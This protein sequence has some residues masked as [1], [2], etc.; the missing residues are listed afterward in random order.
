MNTTFV[1]HRPLTSYFVFTFAISWSA[2]FA[3]VAHRLLHGE[4]IP[5]FSGIPMFPAMLLGPAASGILMTRL[6]DGPAGIRKLFSS[7]IRARVG[8]RWYSILLLPPTAVLAVLLTLKMFVSPAFAP[9]HFFLGVVFGIPAGFFEEIGWTGFAFPRMQARFGTLQAGV[10]LGLLWS[11]WHLPVIDFLGAASPHGTYLPLFFLSFA[12]AMTAMR[13]LI[14]WI[15]ENTQSLL[16]AQF[17]HISSTGAL[18]V[19]GPFQVT[20]AQETA[21]YATYGVGLWIV[22]AALVAWFGPALWGAD[23]SRKVCVRQE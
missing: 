12:T 18:V 10:L 16:L 7:I 23:L 15:Y 14:G 1:A 21:W 6:L 2:A 5:K 3:I 19:F 11:A 4:P 22:V 8:M 9:N 13:V 17:M 20:P